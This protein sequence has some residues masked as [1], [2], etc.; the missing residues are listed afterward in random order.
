MKSITLNKATNFRYLYSFVSDLNP[1]VLWRAGVDKQIFIVVLTAPF[2]RVARRICTQVCCN[3]LSQIPGPE[4]DIVSEAADLVGSGGG[5]TSLIRR[6]LRAHVVYTLTWSDLWVGS[7]EP[8]RDG[9][10]KF[11]CL[12][13]A[14]IS[15][16]RWPSDGI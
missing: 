13:L 4:L 16:L 14:S 6:L 5:I 2:R 7:G 3:G 10:R 11:G 1:V 9:E 12:Q 8:T 15:L